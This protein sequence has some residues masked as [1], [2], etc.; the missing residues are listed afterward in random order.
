MASPPPEPSPLANAPRRYG[1]RVDHFVPS[2]LYRPIGMQYPP[3]AGENT[4]IDMRTL[5]KRRDDLVNW[6]KHLKRRNEL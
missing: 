5:S 1:K 2:I 4:G 3:T 6:E